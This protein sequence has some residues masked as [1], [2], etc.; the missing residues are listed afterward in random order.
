MTTFNGWGTAGANPKGYISG[1]VLGYVSA[2]SL[3]ITSLVCRSGDNTADLSV[4]SAQTL[5]VTTINAANGLER[6]TL[7]GTITTNGTAAV[8]GTASAYLT[9][10]APSNTP[11]TL[12]GTI[13][14][15]GAATT[16]ITGVGT[17]FT[18]EIRPLDLIGN[19]TVGFSQVVS[20]TSDTSLVV[21]SNLTITNGATGKVVEN[22]TLEDSNGGE[23][24]RVIAI[25]D[26]THLTVDARGFS[27]SHTVTGYT[28]SE[29]ISTWFSVWVGASN[30][31]FFSTQRTTPFGTIASVGTAF[32][33]VGYVY[34]DVG[35]DFLG[36][37]WIGVGSDRVFLNTSTENYLLS[38]GT[39]TGWTP[40]DASTWAPSA[41]QSL[42]ATT[43][44]KA[45]GGTIFL[46]ASG[47]GSSTVTRNTQAIS[48]IVG[49]NG[50]FGTMSVPLNG[51][52]VFD[53]AVSGASAALYVVPTGY[54]YS[55]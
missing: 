13:G 18:Q 21:T 12:T 55:I 49:A 10:F 43:L 38:N 33:L 42:L 35:K 8:V 30:I 26:D 11:R 15:G 46:R 3:N 5:D 47:L 20:I 25:A 27:S 28:G 1:G 22:P 48:A 44:G 51:C 9:E 29:D 23:V 19:S 37:T 24:R 34:N 39:Q 50:G 7:T 54:T 17:K 52:Q 16:T 53:Y 14:T 45:V 2:N 40:I 6:K 41:A 31:V 36:G 32:R 4:A